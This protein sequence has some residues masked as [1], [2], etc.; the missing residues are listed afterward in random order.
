LTTIAD[1]CW[2]RHHASAERSASTSHLRQVACDIAPARQ[3]PGLWMPVDKWISA[4]PLL[5][6]VDRFA[7]DLQV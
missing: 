1:H 6:H 5:F 4:P 7:G 3:I 2:T